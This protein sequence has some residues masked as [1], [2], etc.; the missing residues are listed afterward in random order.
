MAYFENFPFIRYQ[1]DKDTIKLYQN[2]SIRPHIR[3]ELLGADVNQ[4]SPYYVQ[5]GETPETLAYDY[6]DDETLHWVIM[7]A[8][9]I[10]NLYTDWPMSDHQM[11]DYIYD[12]YR[13]Q[14]DSEGVE[15]TLSDIQVY[16]YISFTG[17]PN[18][19]YKGAIDLDSDNGPKIVIRP[20]HFVDAN[21][22]EYTY[23]TVFANKD[24]YGRFIDLPTLTPVSHEEYEIS[25]NDEKRQIVIPSQSIATKMKK[26]L[27]KIVNE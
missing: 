18:N 17:N 25:L 20:H 26:E 23:Q 1:F 8:N 6:Y 4:M 5:S 12:K 14:K 10:M 24:A 9:N 19:G 21:G 15:R 13:V 2:I 22:T 11:K 27:R 16:E 7:L 3:E